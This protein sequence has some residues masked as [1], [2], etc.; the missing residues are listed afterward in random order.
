MAFFVLLCYHGIILENYNRIIPFIHGGS[1]MKNFYKKIAVISMVISILSTSS[2]YAFA[3]KIK[4]KNVAKSSPV[5]SV[6]KTKTE[7]TVTSKKNTL[8]AEKTTEKSVEK[9]ENKVQAKKTSKN[10]EELSNKKSKA[11]SSEKD[12]KTTK[13]SNQS[14]VKN[15]SSAVSQKT[16]NKTVTNEKK[17]NSTSN[18]NAIGNKTTSNDDKNKL[19][20][21]IDD[22]DTADGF[23]SIQNN[24]QDK[25]DDCL[26]IKIIG[27]VLISLG[28][29]GFLLSLYWFI[30]KRKISE[31]NVAKPQN[32]KKE[33]YKG[34]H[35]K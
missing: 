14:D 16:E 5:Q 27:I 18:D 22:K 24:T 13:K 17:Q 12:V 34:A 8:S 31:K 29:I 19:E 11:S 9:T 35:F 33:R 28:T 1:L 26:Y 20:I 25:E 10:A 32:S 2:V 23:Q 4:P 15:S 21:A 7:N 30:T 6:T 3:V